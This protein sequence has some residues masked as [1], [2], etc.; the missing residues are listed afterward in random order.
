VAET[1]TETPAPTV[2]ELAI[3]R[4]LSSGG[5]SQRASEV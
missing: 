1:L 4:R 2:D 5:T 3:V